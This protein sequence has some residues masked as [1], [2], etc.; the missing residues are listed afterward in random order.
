MKQLFREYFTY[1]S[2]ERNGVLVLL[3]LVGLLLAFLAS[4]RF[5]LPKEQ[6]DFTAFEKEMAALQVQAAMGPAP[7]KAV[8]HPEEDR[9]ATVIE[10]FL[11]DP[12]TATIADLERLGLS[13]RQAKAVVTYVAKGGSF[14][15]KDDFRKLRVIPATLHQTLEPYISIAPKE[16][17]PRSTASAAPVLVEVN[18]ADSLALIEIDGIGP[19]FASRILKFRNALGGFVSKEQLKEVRGMTDEK[20]NFIAQKMDVDPAALARIN[21]NTATVDELAKHPYITYNLA[22]ALVNYRAMHGKYRKIEDIRASDLV[23]DELYLK[24]APYLAAE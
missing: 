13:P 16:S 20:Y 6:T 8:H 10:H 14:R 17:E 1:T 18:T 7:G 23:N 19:V 9:D 21:L 2:S 11:F 22:R 5:F 24:I 4:Y 12:N 3:S 15:S